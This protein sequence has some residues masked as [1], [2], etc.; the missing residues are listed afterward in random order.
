MLSVRVLWG[1]SMGGDAAEPRLRAL[2]VDE[3][4]RLAPTAAALSYVGALL[5]L[6][7]LIETG[8][9]ARGALWFLCATG[10]TVFRFLAI[11]AY[12]RRRPKSDTEA[13]ARLM[14][15]ANLL[16]GVQWAALGTLLLPDASGY[17]QLFTLMVIVC[18][19]SASIPA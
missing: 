13:W 15:A 5:T 8:D 10:V 1:R 17:R 19:V 3:L 12:R 14:I 9:S 18:F 4:Y 6:G 16:A 11:V 7:V 2:Q